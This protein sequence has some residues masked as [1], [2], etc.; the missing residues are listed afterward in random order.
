MARPPSGPQSPPDFDSFYRDHIAGM[1]EASQSPQKLKVYAPN[2]DTKEARAYLCIREHPKYNQLTEL[3]L[4]HE[5]G[6][7][8]VLSKKVVIL[9]VETGQV[10]YN[11][12]TCPL[13]FG[14][15]V[16]LTGTEKFWLKEN[17]H[18]PAVLE[19]W[20]NPVHEGESEGLNPDFGSESDTEQG[21][22]G[23]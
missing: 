21:D 2:G 9:N 3:F 6:K 5:N 11:P 13:H 10:C 19:L 4:Q 15:R 23:W 16:F 1:F 8:E 14:Q 17:P 22:E 7:C 20:D 18:W 12:R